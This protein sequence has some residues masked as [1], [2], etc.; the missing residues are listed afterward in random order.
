MNLSV[1]S[2]YKYIYFLFFFALLFGCAK[3]NQEETYKPE[4]PEWSKNVSI[5]EVNIRQYTEEGTF[6]AFEKHLPE[7]KEMG[8]GILW[9]MPIH[10]I[11]EVN[12]KGTLGSYYAV[13]DYNAI[14][15]EFGTADDFA[16]LINKIHEMGMHVIIDWV[17]NHTAWDNVWTKTHP[18]FFN[19]DSLGNFYP[20]VPDWH[21]VI[22]LNYDNSEMQTAMI[23]AM[24]YW[25]KTFNIDGYRCDVASMVPVEFWMKARKAL[26]SIKPVFMLAEAN[27]SYLHPAFD[28]TYDWPLLHLQ[29]EIAQGKKNADD[30]V[31]YLE[32]EQKEYRHEDY[33]MV[34]TT[35]HDE[36]SWNG[37]VFERLDGGAE[38]FDILCGTISGMPLIYS[39]Q[40]AGLNKRLNFFEKD[41]IEW[42]EHRF[43]KI[44]ERLNMLKLRNH[45]LWNG[46]YGGK[47]EF[48][49]TNNENV[50]S[51]VRVKDGDKVFVIINL[52]GNEQKITFASNAATGRYKNLFSKEDTIEFLGELKFDLKPWGYKVF[53][54][55][56]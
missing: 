37:T 9:L 28:M 22:D 17:A 40:E 33:R 27:E 18:E 21:D 8:V 25:V 42:K 4:A 7:L 52:S 43:R 55:V 54:K 20:P 44:F 35:N 51:F 2:R 56:H 23:S 50:F 3:Q 14:N 30:L 11:G 49:N 12:R 26:D 6:A 32:E 39:G 45:A 19:R 41:P 29:N 46:K 47:M 16:R 34:F 13:K 48:I 10:P 38:A 36:N 53:V 24:S 5:Y 31:N 15:P 1:L